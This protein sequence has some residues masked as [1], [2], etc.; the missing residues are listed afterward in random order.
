[1]AGAMATNSRSGGGA[2]FAYE[3]LAS[4][5]ALAAL[6]AERPAYG[7]GGPVRLVRLQH[8]SQHPGFDDLTVS[9]DPA[10][11][12]PRLVAVQAKL[13][14][15]VHWS[16][17]T[18]Q[19]V[20]RSLTTGPVP[21][22]DQRLL[23]LGASA[24][25]TQAV[26]RLCRR[27]SATSDPDQFAATVRAAGQETEPV[28]RMLDHLLEE[29]GAGSLRELH[30]LLSETRVSQRDDHQ[31]RED[32]S[33]LLHDLTADAP[34]PVLAAA[35]A[36]IVRAR[37]PESGTL[38]R[39]QL[40]ELLDRQGIHVRRP[41]PDPATTR[42]WIVPG[43]HPG[44]LAARPGV[45]EA[46]DA[47]MGDRTSPSQY[48]LIGPAGYGKSLTALAFTWTKGPEYDCVAWIDCASQ[49]TE[50]LS[51][52]RLAQ[53]FELD[54]PPSASLADLRE[55]VHAAL[56]TRRSWLLVLDNAGAFDPAGQ[57]L[58]TAPGGHL[59]VLSQD[60]SW[61]L[62]P[63]SE[64][65][66]LQAS[67]AAEYL[68]AVTGASDLTTAT[69]I[70]HRLHGLPLALDQAARTILQGWSLPAYLDR[71][72][73]SPALMLDEGL[74][75]TY[76]RTITATWELAVEHASDDE[77]ELLGILAW[78]SPAP[79]PIRVLA[80]DAD[81]DAVDAARQTVRRL[82]ALGLVRVG[83]DH[84]TVTMHGLLQAVLR[85]RPVADG[86]RSLAAGVDAL[87]EHMAFDEDSPT[88]W[89]LTA[90]LLPHAL[91]IARHA[92]DEHVALDRT[93]QL[94]YR[95]GG[96]LTVHDAAQQ[97]YLV[98]LA[99]LAALGD[100]AAAAAVSTL[101][102]EHLDG[103]Q[104]SASSIID[105]ALLGEG[106]TDPRR[107]AE[108]LNEMVI[109]IA[110]I[111]I[112]VALSYGERAMELAASASDPDHQVQLMDNLAWTIQ[113]A[114][115]MDEA[116]ATYDRALA[117]T[118]EPAFSD[119][120]RI[121]NLWNDRS[122]V[123]W[124]QGQLLEAHRGLQRASSGIGRRL[125]DRS[126][127]A[128]LNIIANLG[129]L[130]HALWYLGPAKEQ[131]EAVQAILQERFE[132]HHLSV[133]MG[134]SN[135]GVLLHDFG[136]VEIGRRLV[137]DAL[138]RS[139]EARGPDDRETLIRALFRARLHL[140]E[141]DP[142]PGR[143]AQ[144]DL[145]HHEEEASNDSEITVASRL[146]IARLWPIRLQPL[147]EVTALH[148]TVA[149]LS[150]PLS[151]V[152]CTA[153][154]FLATTMWF[155][156]D[157]EGASEL[158]GQVADTSSEAIGSHHPLSQIRRL[159]AIAL[160]AAAHAT[161]VQLD[162]EQILASFESHHGMGFAA[163]RQ[164]LEQLGCPPI[165]DRDDVRSLALVEEV[166]A[167]QPPRT[168]VAHLL[169]GNAARLALLAQS[170]DGPL[171]RAIAAAAAHFGPWH[172][173]TVLRRALLVLARNADPVDLDQFLEI[174]EPL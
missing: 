24:G 2:G 46:L 150:A 45:F 112:P 115:R 126:P 172:P 140:F 129:A 28:R 1:M 143:A 98:H 120:E 163:F 76:E 99:G 142:E 95:T 113:L 58:P 18:T 65:D 49:T 82:S 15:P 146:D 75:P 169:E 33:Q 17:P 151:N 124:S 87:A 104:V 92:I 78:L 43:R 141:G 164:D 63:H 30:V 149:G 21:D 84:D 77:V 122:L 53:S 13:R 81:D 66:V 88:S 157:R 165:S 138:T 34:V 8:E 70:A 109:S 101:D 73:R 23:L 79:L 107:F 123:F 102:L 132:G 71:L 19:A 48:A 42:I 3:S 44:R 155:H 130:S 156:D 152:R 6:L 174:P 74:P 117:L 85:D 114:G 9:T 133:L 97:A 166:L 110:D 51:L 60:R 160:E 154:T 105:P 80:A 7:L 103:G 54:L 40:I 144:L 27:A 14:V 119:L 158:F 4:T 171:E 125:D 56:S 170:D 36:D 25:W 139:S 161:V 136:E 59:L 91:A 26:D 121:P 47:A 57:W 96:Y 100:Q 167:A 135:L 50:A 134:M 20:L 106:A 41:R 16:N 93:A 108:H 11:P 55:A 68:L 72:T 22:G 52:Q 83:V 131:L 90:E 94:L 116:V 159:K 5:L 35:L 168:P 39:D 62:S 145:L 162:R 38:E 67:D 147:D 127:P 29:L 137:D 111:S 64:L 128:H 118:T 153:D 61:K 10:A 31:L 32:T 86:A 37:A 69:A 89:A 148:E 173:L 12:H